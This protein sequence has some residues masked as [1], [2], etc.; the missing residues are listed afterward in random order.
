MGKVE[1]NSQQRV[2]M[3]WL[4]LRKLTQYAAVS[5]RTVREWI[6]RAKN[7]LPAVQVDK[8]ILVRRTQ[9]DRWLEEHPL[10]P[11]ESVNID[12]FVNDLIGSLI[13]RDLNGREAQ[14]V[15]R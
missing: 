6:H 4:D 5:E 8:K 11:A 1:A 14:K 9:L 3:E 7:P 13:R 10:R 12:G 15:Q 2:Q